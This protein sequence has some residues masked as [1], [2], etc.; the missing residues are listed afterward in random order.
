[1]NILSNPIRRVGAVCVAGA[2]VACAAV[3]P[4]V[5]AAATLPAPAEQ[6]TFKVDVKGVQTTVW[7]L[8]HASQGPCDPTQR[9]GGKETI[10]F[11]SSRPE[12]MI[13]RRYGKNYV[14]FGDPLQFGGNDFVTSATVTRNG[15]IVSSKVASGCG[16]NGGSGPATPDCGT[17]KTG[18]DLKLEYANDRHGFMLTG[19][20]LG[21]LGEPFHDCPWTGG[22]TSFPRIVERQRTRPIVAAIPASDLFDHALGQHV[23]LAQGV[24]RVNSGGV[25]AVTR[26]HWDVRLTRVGH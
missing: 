11:R 12:R 7:T 3:S 6:Q 14:L 16:A 23:I 5:A 9:G 26:L 19:G 13:A 2:A 15:H 21:T 17:K 25:K 10:V 1:M 18:L 22:V 4:S 24:E 8:Q 20:D